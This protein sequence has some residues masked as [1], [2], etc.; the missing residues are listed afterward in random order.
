MLLQRVS[1]Y[2]RYRARRMECKRNGY[3]QI[4]NRR[5]VKDCIHNGHNITLI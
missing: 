4:L 5:A 1:E 2:R 3:A